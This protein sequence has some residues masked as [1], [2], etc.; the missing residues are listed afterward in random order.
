MK[1]SAPTTRGGAAHPAQVDQAGTTVKPGKREI[2]DIDDTFC[3]AHCGQS[4]VL[5]RASRRARLCIVT[6]RLRRHRPKTRIV[7]RGDS[8]YGRV[9]A[10]DWAEDND[11][12]YILG[13]PAMPCSTPWRRPPTISACITRSVARR[14]C[15]LLPGSCTGQ[16]LEAAAQSGGAARMLAADCRGRDRYAPGGRHPLCRHLASFSYLAMSLVLL[17]C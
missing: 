2:I 17:A 15:A 13:S 11:T 1:P 7:W 6:K 5:E 8:H 3:A 16:Q 9:E 14:S 10:T 12:D 4:R